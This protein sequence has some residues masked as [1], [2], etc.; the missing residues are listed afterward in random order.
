MRKKVRLMCPAHS[1]F[2]GATYNGRYL[3]KT[4]DG[5]VFVIGEPET[6]ITVMDF[7]N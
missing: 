6:I 5:I 7:R 2:C 3:R 1:G 4:K